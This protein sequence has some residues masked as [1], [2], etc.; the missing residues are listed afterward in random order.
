MDEQTA[1]DSV[2]P[3]SYCLSMAEGAGRNPGQFCW[4]I[5]ISGQGINIL[6]EKRHPVGVLFPLP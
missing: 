5:K 2:R 1:E 3:D 6:T 4:I